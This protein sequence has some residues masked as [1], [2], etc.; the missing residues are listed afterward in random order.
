[1][2]RKTPET[3]V[4]QDGRVQKSRPERIREIQK[5][6][7]QGHRAAQIAKALGVGEQQI[8]NIARA[9]GIVL[10]DAF[11]SK[12]LRLDSKRILTETINGVDAYVS[13]LSMLD[14]VGLPELETQEQNDLM[15]ALSRS[16]NGLKKLRTKMEKQYAGS[17]A[18][19][20]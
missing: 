18:T 3:V 17:S 14:D 19:A 8:R 16:I 15:Q 12:T 4:R 2:P 1:M 6:V 20:A 10:P 11:I 13:G 5:L 9:E 7:E